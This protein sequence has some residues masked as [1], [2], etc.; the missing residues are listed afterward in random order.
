MEL[1]W[2]VRIV[3]VIVLHNVSGVFEGHLCL[4][5]WGGEK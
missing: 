5:F 4:G 2:K 3:H 1:K